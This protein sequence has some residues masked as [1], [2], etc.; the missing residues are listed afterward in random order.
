VFQQ[1]DEL[2]LQPVLSGR[3]HDRL[4]RIDGAWWFE[5]RMVLPDLAG[6]LRRHMADRA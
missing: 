4:V 3:Y 6:D 5:E 2:A 1:T